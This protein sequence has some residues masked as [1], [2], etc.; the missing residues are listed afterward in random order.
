MPSTPT[1][2]PSLPIHS[3]P[4][5]QGSGSHY[6]YHSRNLQEHYKP[7]LKEDLKHKRTIT[8]DAFLNEVLHLSTDWI[9]RNASHIRGIVD[10]KPFLA[11]IS[12]Y[13]EPMAHETHR[14]SPFIVLA[15]HVVGKLAH[16]S[17]SNL[18]FC[19][20]DP[21]HVR[22]SS[23]QRK[24]DVVGVIW[25]CLQLA[26]RSSVDNL[27]KDGPN[28]QPF[29]WTELLAF[30]EFKLNRYD[31]SDFVGRNVQTRDQSSSK[32]YDCFYAF[33]YQRFVLAVVPSTSQPSSSSESKS[34]KRTTP[35]TDPPS[36]T[37]I[38]RSGSRPSS[39]SA[40]GSKRISP[41]MSSD[42]P[43]KSKK[44][45]AE[46]ESLADDSMLQCASYALEI[47]SHGGLRSH[48]IGA[49][50]TDDTIELLYYDRSIVI[51]SEP[52]NFI[53]DQPRFIAVLQALASL[54]LQ[55]WGYA[56]NV[57]KPAPLLD[58]PLRTTDI[59][60]GL[61]LN[62][63]NGSRLR[64]GGT[65]FHQHGLIGRGTCVVRATCIEKG[66]GVSDEAWNGQLIVKLSWPARSRMSEQVIIE[67]ARSKADNDEHRWVL[68]HL[69]KVL[70]AEDVDANLLS[71]ALIDRLG[72]GYEAHIL[73]MMVQ[74]ELFPITERV[75]AADLAESF[76]EIFQ[77][78]YSRLLP[79]CDG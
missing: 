35:R 68:K 79:Y 71:Q 45:K 11:M 25:R 27:M 58:N 8:F 10:T 67:Q 41:A 38:T 50:V 7:Y 28:G 16:N 57:L 49:L 62:L 70:H 65:V 42:T 36:R 56:A 47:L 74:E 22:G 2:P 4:H 43:H 69:P 9:E 17:E 14:Y 24:P 61:E 29:W 33:S 3:T 34:R 6:S 18:S 55:Q 44:L 21:I 31:L 51:V 15:N 12:K 1:K 72:D 20:N 52:L 66:N 53:K 30:L 37:M 59:F 39:T 13:C 19:R 46:G 32:S 77:C 75:T 5:S 48:V 60:D 26:A 54:S 23:G 64:L 40:S 78:G 76:R 63:C 73:R